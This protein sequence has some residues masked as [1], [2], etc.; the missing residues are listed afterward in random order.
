MPEYEVRLNDH[1][2]SALN[3]LISEK[4]NALFIEKDAVELRSTEIRDE[5]SNFRA[6]RDRIQRA[7]E[8]RPEDLEPE[9]A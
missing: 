5:I 2:R 6:L 7:P 3:A 4:L 9:D 8:S 1:S